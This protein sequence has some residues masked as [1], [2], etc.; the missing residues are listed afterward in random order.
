MN[1]K[2]PYFYS[3]T[4]RWPS[5]TVILP[6]DLHAVALKLFERDGHSRSTV[7]R[8][9][10]FALIG[11]VTGG[12]FGDEGCRLIA[13]PTPEAAEKLAAWDRMIM[14]GVA[15]SKVFRA[16]RQKQKPEQEQGQENG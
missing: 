2:T 7:V 3:R 6:P 9:L 5:V 12:V 1:Q 15:H 8:M 11:K 16:Q 4:E 13:A 10:I 14:T